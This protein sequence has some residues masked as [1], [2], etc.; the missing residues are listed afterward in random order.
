MPKQHGF[1]CCEA[2]EVLG[3][4]AFGSGKSRALCIKLIN[5]ATIP[6]AREALIR[7]TLISLKA[8]TLK[9]LLEPDGELPPVLPAGRYEHNKSEKVIR[10]HGGGEIVYFG[11]DDP[12]K[13]GSYNLSG[14]AVDQAEELDEADWTALRGRIR[15]KLEGVADQLYAVCNP[16]SPSHFLARRFGLSEGHVCTPGCVAV[17]SRTSD[18]WHLPQA[19]LNDLKTFTGVAYKRFVLGQWAGSD[20]L[21]YDIWDRRIHVRTKTGP[22]RRCVFG[23]D[24]GY[25][26]PGCL[27]VV[28][29]D[30]DGRK[31][32]AEEVYSCRQ[33]SG[34]W[35][36]KAKELVA[37]WHPE[38]I[39]VDP[40]AAGFIAELN[41]AGLPAIGAENDRRDGVRLVK[42]ALA[43]PGDGR[44]RMTVDPACLN[45]IREF[46]TWENKPDSDDFTKENDDAMDALRYAVEGLGEYNE[47]PPDRSAY[48]AAVRVV[49]AKR[50]PEMAFAGGKDDLSDIF[51][52]GEDEEQGDVTV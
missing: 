42:A 46:E 31:H 35:T 2:R 8:T 48:L 25:T 51:G 39:L 20:L 49:N 38:A 16:S 47:P 6:G 7:K 5:R 36:E 15:L 23:M 45:T 43:I 50:P 41:A 24:E 21:V 1:I 44:P 40:S 29:E 32:V 3:S 52:S 30:G 4:G 22:W 28:G 17:L 10:I 9:T 18:N 37:K 33:L 13:I 14:A 11:L 26:H 27:L 12:D 19:Y 34:W